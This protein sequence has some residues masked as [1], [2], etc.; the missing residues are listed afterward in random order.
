[1][2]NFNLED[3]QQL[4]QCYDEIDQIEDR[5]YCLDEKSNWT[6]LTIQE[7]RNSLILSKRNLQKILLTTKK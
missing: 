2:S 5:L 1:M 3:I 7:I 6:N 4:I